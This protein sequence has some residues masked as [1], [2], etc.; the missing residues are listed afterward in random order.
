MPFEGP[1]CAGR[2][3]SFRRQAPGSIWKGVHALAKSRAAKEESEAYLR[4]RLRSTTSLVLADFR[5]LDV[6]EVTELRRRLRTAGVEYRVI[7]NTLARRAAREAGVAGLD[8]MLAGPTAVAFGS[9]DPTAAARELNTFGREHPQ[10]AIKGG[11]LEGRTLDAAEVQ[12]LAELPGRE[13][14]LARVLGA[15]MAPLTGL[16]TVLEAPMRALAIGTEAL[17]RQREVTV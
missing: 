11:L 15:M 4:E 17:R 12:E 6:A 1:P 16:A 9:A 10:L 3:L 13:V 8:S 5:G 14:L 2:P 7:K